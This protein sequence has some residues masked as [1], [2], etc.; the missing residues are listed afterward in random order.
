MSKMYL[1]SVANMR[2]FWLT[3]VESSSILVCSAMNRTQK[4]LRC[5]SVEQT[6]CEKAGCL[7]AGLLMPDG[8]AV[9]A[10]V[11]IDSSSDSEWGS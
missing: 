5:T 4:Q 7:N 2:L 9:S 11:D 8:T 1:Q 10:A 3:F 6:E